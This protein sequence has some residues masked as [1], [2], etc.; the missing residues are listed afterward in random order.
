[1]L[2]PLG[3]YHLNTNIKA[4]LFAA[5]NSTLL[6]RC[7]LPNAIL[8]NPKKWLTKAYYMYLLFSVNL[9]KRNN[10]MVRKFPNGRKK[11]WA[12]IASW[13]FPLDGTML[14]HPSWCYH[15]DATILMLPT[16]LC[17]QDA[18]ILMLILQH[19]H[20][21]ATL[22]KLLSWYYHPNFTIP[23][24]SSQPYLPKATIP[25]LPSQ[26]YLPN[27]T[28]LM[29]LSQRYQPDATVPS[30]R[31]R[32]YRLDATILMLCPA[33]THSAVPMQ[34]SWCYHPNT[35]IIPYKESIA[36]Q[37]NCKKACSGCW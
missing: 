13:H 37:T 8:Q 18:T 32:C 6:S 17:S 15:P 10:Y 20:S 34:P 23:M 22:L 28:T 4:L 31:S 26:Y 7:Y 35:K 2:L 27:A 19:N 5:T 14:I 36:Q 29:L 3:C 9:E 1:M 24:L 21:E 16:K 30:L 11:K 33:A 12:T 25:K